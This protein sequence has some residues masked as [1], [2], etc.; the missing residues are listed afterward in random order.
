MTTVTDLRGIMLANTSVETANKVLKDIDL[1]N[2]VLEGVDFS[3]YTL[4][5]I[6]FTKCVLKNCRFRNAQLKWCDF[7]YTIIEKGTFEDAII[8]FC[9]FYRAFFDG[10]IIFSNSKISNC[11]LNKT[12]IGESAIIRRNNLVNDQIIQQ[13]KM[14]YCEFL[15]KWPGERTNDAGIP[16]MD[17]NHNLGM[18]LVNRWQEAEDIYKRLNALWS[19]SGFIADA[20]WA[21]VQGRRMER[22]RMIMQLIQQ[23]KLSCKEKLKNIW[24]IIT[25][26]ISDI[27]FGYGESMI[28]MIITYVITIFIF[29][30]IFY[31]NTSII[32]YTQALGISLKNMVGMDDDI[33]H[34]VSPLV[35]MLNILQTTI[36]IILTGIFGFILGNK[37][38]N[39]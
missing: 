16:W 20:N 31:S 7:R 24:K 34:D 14:K 35:D 15:T 30:W 39:Q 3:H 37:I 13:N 12:H 38:R 27:L 23:N 4:E 2:Q 18:V 17:P 22:K 9:D 33:L 8:E 25:N 28:K 5:K 11:S 10:V 6:K 26:F 36:G 19:A 32:E 21:Y 1:S 29:A